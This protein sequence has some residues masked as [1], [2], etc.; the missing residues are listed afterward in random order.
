MYHFSPMILLL[1]VVGV[2]LVLPAVLS[3]LSGTVVITRGPWRQRS[4]N[5]ISGY[6]GQ[7]GARPKSASAERAV[8]S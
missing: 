5:A 7:E 8:V 3:F 4:L 2:A 6:Q 1:C